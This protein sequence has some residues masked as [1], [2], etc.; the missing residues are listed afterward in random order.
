MTTQF[1]DQFTRELG[2]GAFSGRP[3]PDK[4]YAIDDVLAVAKGLLAELKTL[5]R[6]PKELAAG[7]G[8]RPT[9]LTEQGVRDLVRR[10]NWPKSTSVF[11][12]DL[13]DDEREEYRLALRAWEVAAIIDLMMRAINADYGST[14]YRLAWPPPYKWPSS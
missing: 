12:P 9:A 13:T 10:L 4:T 14:R 8:S 2:I 6:T 5:P 1:I 11:P 7:G 3:P